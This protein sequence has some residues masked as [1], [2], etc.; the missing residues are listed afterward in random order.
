[1]KQK[2]KSNRPKESESYEDKIMKNR[3]DY[4]DMLLLLVLAV[5][6]TTLVLTFS[7]PQEQTQNTL[8]SIKT[9]S[10]CSNL[11]L[12]DTSECLKNYVGT[13]YKY[14]LSN[15]YEENFT[16]IKEQGGVC[17]QYAEFYRDSLINLSFDAKN[18]AIDGGDLSHEFTITWTKNLTD[19]SYCVLDENTLVGCNNLGELNMTLYKELVK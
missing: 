13:F 4:L 3:F 10:Q 5:S 1:M 14:N 19:G 2:L 16:K 11:S 12:R 7:Y 8:N 17:H 18:V 9:I 15:L 6:I